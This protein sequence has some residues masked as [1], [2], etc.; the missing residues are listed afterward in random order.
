MLVRTVTR[1]DGVELDAVLGHG[2]DRRGVVDDLGLHRHLHRLEH[3]AAGQVDGRGALEGQ[4]DVGLVGRDQGVDHPHD[5]AAGQVVRLQVVDGDV[6]PGLHRADARGDDGGGRHAAQPHADQGEQTR[7]RRPE[8]QAAIHSGIGTRYSTSASDRHHRH[9]QA[10]AA[11]QSGH[12]FVHGSFLQFGWVSQ[13]PHDDSV[14]IHAR[15]LDGCAGVDQ[16]AVGDHVHAPA[17]DL[18]NAG[19]PQ[20]RHGAPL[21]AQPA[22]VALGRRAVGRAGA[23]GRPPGSAGARTA[24]AAGSAAAPGSA[25]SATSSAMTTRHDGLDDHRRV[26]PAPDHA[27]HQGRRAGPRMPSA[28]ATPKPGMTKISSASSTQ[29]GAGQQQFLPAGQLH[30]P[31]APEEQRQA[32]D[33]H[34]R[35]RCRSRACAS[36]PGCRACRC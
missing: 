5:V 16:Y 17:V 24:G 12:E 18:G 13:S 33:A 2:V 11:D 14:A 4:R 25:S 32:A 7:R 20:H 21:L 9:Q 15:H 3:V 28:P 29:P 31:V 6:E 26:S 23:R 35:R 27:Q 19:R 30:Q 8:A 22:L 1:A 10:D 34:A 36:R